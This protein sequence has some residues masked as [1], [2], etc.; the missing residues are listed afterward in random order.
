MPFCS[1]CSVNR[2][3]KR[4]LNRKRQGHQKGG[5]VKD[6]DFPTFKFSLS[7]IQRN[8]ELL[9]KVNSK[10]KWFQPTFLGIRFARLTPIDYN[11]VLRQRKPNFIKLG[12]NHF[13][14]NQLFNYHILLVS[15]FQKRESWDNRKQCYKNKRKINR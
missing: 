3:R 13:N 4:N 9:A 1:E 11:K 8:Y 6:S 2:Q 7:L 5:D 12:W 15:N 14:P 10:L